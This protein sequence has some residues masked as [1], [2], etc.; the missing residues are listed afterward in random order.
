MDDN[1]DLEQIRNK[2]HTNIEKSQLE[3]E[4]K[5]NLRRR[6]Y[7]VGDYYVEIRNI[8]TTSGINKKLM[9]KFKGSYVVKTVLDNDRFIITDVERFQL[10]QRPY[11]SVVAPDQMRPYI[12]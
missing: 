12:H 7:K 11:T 5:Y 9:P 4:K 10:T 1:R 2:A 3:N 6:S 8:D